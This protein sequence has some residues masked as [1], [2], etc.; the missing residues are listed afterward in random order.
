MEKLEEVT[1]VGR[2]TWEYKD[3]TQVKQVTTLVERSYRTGIHGYKTEK[4]LLK[5][6]KQSI[7]NT[8]RQ[9]HEVIKVEILEVA[10]CVIKQTEVAPDTL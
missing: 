5:N 10:T 8:V 2:I 9:G 6:M 1:K 7:V 3:G 4:A